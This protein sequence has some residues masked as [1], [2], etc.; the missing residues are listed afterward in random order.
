MVCA[1][2]SCKDVSETAPAERK[3]GYTPELKSREDSLL[4]DVLQG[5]DEAM[6]KMFK[7]S[8]QLERVQVRIDSMDQLGASQKKTA[9]YQ[10]WMQLRESLQ[11]AE[12][13][14]NNWMEGFKIDSFQNEKESRER[15]LTEEKIKVA[16]V[17]ERILSSLSM[18]DSLLLDK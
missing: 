7:L 9:S 3:N 10:Q 16:L 13:G 2:L 14:M 1:L 8:K 15:Y 12:Y 6:A 18:A 4:H 17:K 11:S 5:H